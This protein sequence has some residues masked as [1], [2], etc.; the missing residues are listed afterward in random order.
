[1][2]KLLIGMFTLLLLVACGQDPKG[3]VET[4][5]K[6]L[7]Q[8]EITEASKLMSKRVTMRM[9]EQKLNA[10]LG[11][12]AKKMQQKGGIANLTTKG[13]A[14]GEI[15]QF[16]VHIEYKDGSKFNEKVNVSKEEDGWKISPK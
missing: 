7:D 5:Y 15:G 8:G 2:R 4:F 9:G 13:E 3:V 10:M 6:K 14:K 11:E 16:D 1:M 12:Q